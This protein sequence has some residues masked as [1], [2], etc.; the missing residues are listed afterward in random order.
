MAASKILVVEDESI[1]AND[2]KSSLENLG[3]TVPAIAS[4]GEDAVNRIAELSLD[5]V[6]MD[7]KLKGDMDGIRAAEIIGGDYEI[8]VI[9]LTAY[10]D[11][12]TIERARKTA[13]FGFVLK[14]FEERELHT[15]IE[16]AL[17]KHETDRK[18]KESRRWLDAV[19][20]SIGDAVITADTRGRV[21]F[22]NRMAESLTG[23]ENGQALGQ[24]IT[25][26]FNIINET[27]RVVIESPVT[28]ALN[29]EGAIKLGNHT[30][31]IS[32][33]G[34]EIPVD[35]SAAPVKDDKG[36]IT[37]VVLV[38]KDITERRKI[39][40]E[41]IKAR[42]MESIGIL[43]GGLAHDFNNILTGILGNINLAR[44]YIDENSQ[45]YDNLLKAE[46]ASMRA[47]NLTRQ[48][49]TFAKGGAPVKKI[50]SM[51]ET[52]KDAASFAVSGS[53][54]RCEFNI[55]DDLWSVNADEGQIN[56]VINNL[57]LNSNY[58][59]PGGGTIRVRAENFLAGKDFSF[60]V[61][62]GMYVKISVEDQGCGISEEHISKVFDPYF[63]TRETGSGLGLATSFSIIKSHG[64]YIFVESETGAG[65]TFSI[66]L[67][68][69]GHFMEPEIRGVEKKKSVKGK[70][71]LM[72][73]E[74][75][76]RTVAGAMLDSLGYE[77]GYAC[78]GAEAVSEYKKAMNSE[79]P[80]EAV[81]LDL[82]IPAGMGG[83]ETIRKLVKINQ[84][85]K[86]IVSSGYSADPIMAD[87][88]AYGF[89]GVIAKPY[90]IN[91]L[92]QVVKRVLSL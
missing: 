10:A 80:Y 68:A 26:V 63:T 77:V 38:F 59:M 67:P 39:E 46:R 66:Y 36:N 89:R 55:P 79:S 30:I 45:G 15:A 21:T 9:F 47:T 27:T 1:V 28:K 56:Q 69:T 20:K 40:E 75:M 81:I 18:V 86:A 23:W 32:R 48:L 25:R 5:L 8:P 91:D 70:I 51:G 49:L 57:I 82:T 74:E 92:G 24:D 6:L 84:D 62:E 44:V 43:A 71:L 76:I 72:D 87:Y 3:Y 61:K 16:I 31:L 22:M 4:S 37:G 78:D 58:A 50:V 29:M 65:A 17:Y 35:D 54:V 2:I 42:K 85:V 64:G 73:D 52:I 7:I 53:N 11:G 12:E 41:K 34:L 14:P 83:K 88:T 60:H 19:L 13:P 90:R 33:N